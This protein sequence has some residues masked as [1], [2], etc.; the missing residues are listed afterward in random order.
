MFLTD[1]DINEFIRI[2]K[3]EFGGDLSFAEASRMAEELMALFV[4]LAE[5]EPE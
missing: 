3:E 4:M 1:D 2:H 5:D